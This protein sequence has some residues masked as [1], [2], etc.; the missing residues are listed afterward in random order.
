[1]AS[2]D[3][4]PFNVLNSSLASPRKVSIGWMSEGRRLGYGYTLVAE[5]EVKNDDKQSSKTSWTKGESM[6]SANISSIM[7]RLNFRRWSGATTFQKS[8]N[9]SD[10]ASCNSVRSTPLLRVANRRKAST[11][12][13]RRTLWSSK[14]DNSSIQRLK[15]SSELD[16]NVHDSI[17]TT[18]TISTKHRKESQSVRNMLAKQRRVKHTSHNPAAKETTL[19]GRGTTRPKKGTQIMKLK[20][21]RRKDWREKLND[22]APIVLT[23][24][25]ARGRASPDTIGCSTEADALDQQAVCRSEDYQDP[26]ERAVSETISDD[27]VSL[28]Q[29]CLELHTDLR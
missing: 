10:S 1:M 26:L 24:R 4:E 5:D 29:D 9:V 22:D 11:L 21:I 2:L 27:W 23:K 18:W 8:A 19:G 28:Y 3:S 15:G 12:N 17:R 7:D 6:V 16:E 13:E 14:P 20:M 25:T